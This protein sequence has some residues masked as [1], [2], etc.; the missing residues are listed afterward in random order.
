MLS[1]SSD[2]HL[3]WTPHAASH[4]RLLALVV[5]VAGATAAAVAITSA[6]GGTSCATAADATDAPE[7]RITALAGVDLAPVA[8]LP[9]VAA[10]SG[11]YPAV[12]TSLSRGGHERSVRLEAR[13]ALG[14]AGSPRRGS[15]VV[16]RG[17]AL[18]LALA[19]GRSVTVTTTAGPR[20]M[21]VATIAATSGAGRVAYV[22]PADLERVAPNARVHESTL[23]LRL[24]DPERSGR[25][26]A[27]VS[28]AYPGPQVRIAR[29]SGAR[30]PGGGI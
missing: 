4:R 6:V 11:P 15:L 29:V 16:E 8:R 23:L 28:R 25:L 3:G 19:P 21:R 12:A 13:P 2:T 26:A 20:Q 9:G 7:I 5:A 17:L 18:A 22:V 27:W 30:C 1:T 10:S 24:E 14:S